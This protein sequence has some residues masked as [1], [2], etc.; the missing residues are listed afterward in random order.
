LLLEV[1]VR[2]VRFVA[3]LIC[4]AA[5]A[6]CGGGS[7]G[8]SSGGGGGGGTPP[9]SN[10]SQQSVQR[11][12]VQS[13]LSG[14]QAYESYEGGGSLTSFTATRA[15]TAAVRRRGRAVLTTRRR[16][17]AAGCD[18]GVVQTEV[19]NSSGTVVTV[20][21]SVYYDA[22]CDN[23]ESTLVWAASETSSTEISGPATLTN[24]STTGAVTQTANAT[25][26]FYLNSQDEL[27]GLSILAT[28]IVANGVSLG[29]AGIACN[30]PS[31]SSFS[32][33]VAAATNIASSSLEDGAN[34]SLSGS[35]TSTQLTVSMSIS[36]YQGALNAL[37]ITA[38][39]FPDWTISPS[40]DLLG[41]LSM[42][43]TESPTSTTVS[44]TMTDSTNNATLTMSGSVG[45]TITGTL[46]NNATGTAVATFS[47]NA[48]G[49]GTVTYGNG[50]TA[51]IVDYMVQG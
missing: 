14:L 49:N 12:D 24:Y 8:S 47:V 29:Q 39:T 2:Y 4:V 27:T 43:G 37:S 10:I 20:T 6:A 36:T 32:C 23:I 46:T 19:P 50:S 30:V 21:V 26:A 7:G 17:G 45:G 9:Q 40:A 48:Q 5:L 51:S 28:S 41:S 11:T 25:I 42:S 35:Q 34:V 33:G 44:L 22:A 16:D 15:L 1:P 3:A 38:A 18:D 13:G 31:L